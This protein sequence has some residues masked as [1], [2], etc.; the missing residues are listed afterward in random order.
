MD[1]HPDAGAVKVNQT[2]VCTPVSKLHHPSCELQELVPSVP[3]PGD[4]SPGCADAQVL[5]H[6]HTIPKP[7]LG[8]AH[9]SS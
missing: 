6:P 9:T 5:S 8:A 7:K 3:G 2:E 4:T 1:T